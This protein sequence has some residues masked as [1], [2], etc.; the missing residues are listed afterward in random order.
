MH[1]ATPFSRAPCVAVAGLSARMLAQ[2]AARAGLNP[3]AL[4]LFG[5]RDTREHAS[6]WFD[7]GGEGLSI[8][9]ARLVDALER[10]ARLPRMLGFIATSGMEPHMDALFGQPRLPRLIG[11]GAGATAAVRDPRRFFALLDELGIGHPEVSFARPEKPEGWIA[12][13]AD[14]CGGVHIEAASSGADVYF[15]R[16]APGQPMSALFIGARREATLIG[17]AEQLSVEA[18]ALP[19]VHAGSL[20][21]VDLPRDTVK[22]LEQAIR[23]IVWR[24]DLAGL[25]S[26]DFLLDGDAIRVL[27]INA[28]PSSTMTL[29]DAVWPAVWPCGLIGC[30]I[31]AC[32]DGHL[33]AEPPAP[34]RR[35]GQRVV[36]APLGFTVSPAFSD[37]CS[38]DPACHDVPLAGTRIEA[39]Q[40]VCTL[41]VT[42]PS[43]D[44]VRRE[45]ERQHALFLQR[46]ETCRESFH[47]VIPTH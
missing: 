4:D 30:H 33:P 42:A 43:V 47:D 46:I 19:F 11:N 38:G 27:E 5:D 2:A 44:A 3:V 32:L 34:P 39:G 28:R 35:A 9:R 12:K 13:R 29:Y 45:L 36:F 1:A 24:T 6:A 25:N 22:A 41:V 20:G 14:G 17:F 31:D 18:G 26:I 21:P 8:D 23:A 40:P 15:Q 7:I 16:R 37:A 10:T